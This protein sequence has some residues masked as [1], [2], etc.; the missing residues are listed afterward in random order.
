MESVTQV[1]DDKVA[2]SENTQLRKSQRDAIK[3]K[4]ICFICD[5]FRI[6]DVGSFNIAGVGRCET[7]SARERIQ[8][9]TLLFFSNQ[10]YRFHEEAKRLHPLQGGQSFDLYAI[11]IFYHK[12]CYLKYAINKPLRKIIFSLRKLKEHR[13]KKRVFFESYSLK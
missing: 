6:T 9:R 5:K 10:T 12:L 8:L 3:K 4:C 2:E 7:E 11:N 1:F 13:S